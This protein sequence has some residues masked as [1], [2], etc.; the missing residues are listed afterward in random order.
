MRIDAGEAEVG[1]LSVVGS[2]GSKNGHLQ[3]LLEYSF[4]DHQ[5]VGEECPVKEE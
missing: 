5:P 3:P 4:K 2:S 1:V